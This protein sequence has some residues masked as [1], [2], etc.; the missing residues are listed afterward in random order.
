MSNGRGDHNPRPLRNQRL[1]NRLDNSKFWGHNINP[2]FVADCVS[3]FPHCNRFADQFDGTIF[4]HVNP[5]RTDI[6]KMVNVVLN[7]GHI[8]A[9]FRRNRI[10]CRWAVV[11][12]QLDEPAHNPP[13]G[14]VLLSRHRIAFRLSRWL[15]GCFGA[16]DRLAAFLAGHY[17]TY[18]LRTLHRIT[19]A[20]T[21]GCMVVTQCT[22]HPAPH[23]KTVLN[24]Q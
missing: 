21:G 7:A 6:A 12:G 19:Y 20:S 11:N 1:F 8:N 23:T 5:L 16:T 17:V 3:G 9:T 13:S 10:Q 24:C 14:R 15:A 4:G 22:Y 18:G 2:V